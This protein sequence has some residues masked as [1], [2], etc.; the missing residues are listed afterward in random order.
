MRGVGALYERYSVLC[1]VLR[2]VVIFWFV[3]AGAVWSGCVWRVSTV[4]ALC[5]VVAYGAEFFCSG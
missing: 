4:V 2:I 5:G 3:W 1:E